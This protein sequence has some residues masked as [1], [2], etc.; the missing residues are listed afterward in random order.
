MSLRSTRSFVVRHLPWALLLGGGA[1]MADSIC[2]VSI[3]WVTAGARKPAASPSICAVCQKPFQR[4]RQAQRT[5][6]PACKKSLFRSEK[7]DSSY[8][9][10]RNDEKA[11][12]AQAA[13]GFL[14]LWPGIKPLSDL[15]CR[16]MRVTPTGQRDQSDALLYL[17]MNE[18]G[19]ATAP[20][21]PSHGSL[22]RS[23][24]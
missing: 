17:P 21:V 4:H 9:G 18:I 24:K 10:S 2:A 14:R 7:R 16:T 19:S 8:D 12:P 15:E 1:V 11:V 6:S 13:A 5:C 23:S 20:T 22:E 3:C